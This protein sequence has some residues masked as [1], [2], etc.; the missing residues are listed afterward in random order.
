MCNTK[1]SKVS[2]DT[3]NKLRVLFLPNWK[4]QRCNE[5][6]KDKQ[7]PDY[8]IEGEDYWF[9]RYFENKPVV[10]I[11]D[12]SSFKWLENF[13][14]NKIRFYIIQAIKVIPKLSKYDIVMSHGMQSGIVIALWRRFFKSKTRHIVF[15]IGS[16]NSAAENGTALKLM[17]FAS[18]SID[19]IIYHT[20]S[21][22]EYY[23]QFFPWIVDK[24]QF[25]KFGTDYDYFCEEN[26]NFPET[27]ARQ[28]QEIGCKK[29]YCICIGYTKRDWDT[30]VDAFQMTNI[31]NLRLLLVG[32]VDDKYSGIPNIEQ[33]GFVDIQELKRLITD[34][35]FCV[36]PLKS[37]NYSYGQMTLMQQ[38]AMG[39]CVIA[40]KVPSLVDYVENRKTAIL[41]NP[42]DADE[43]AEIITE[44]DGNEALRS[45]I[46]NNAVSYIKIVN[47]EKIMAKDI[48]KT[49]KAI[50]T[51][52]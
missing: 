20:S 32:H 5:A 19:G 35:K 1:N 33:V 48:E 49:C 10:D 51:G 31:K 47:N 37:Y 40:A 28:N 26:G 46:S 7:P 41:Y 14:K 17:R 4:V 24:S 25:I 52:I 12:V 45:S 21:Q 36:L 42:E 38:M 30:L 8:Y 18:K 13:E 23:K 6:P 2:L 29:E 11:I 39:K 9:F 22:K 15:D 27:I 34:A 43:L 50:L 44:I 16:F 3:S